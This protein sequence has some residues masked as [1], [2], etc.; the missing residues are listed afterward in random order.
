MHIE[1]GETVAWPSKS[2]DFTALSCMK[3]K[4]SYTA[5]PEILKHLFGGITKPK[6]KRIETLDF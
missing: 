2:P 5:G 1:G 4:V 6:W 3:P